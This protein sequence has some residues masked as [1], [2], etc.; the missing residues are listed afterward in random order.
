MLSAENEL[1]VPG[2]GGAELMRYSTGSF[3]SHED[4]GSAHSTGK[5]GAILFANGTTLNELIDPIGERAQLVE[6][7]SEPAS[8]FLPLSECTAADP[9]H[10]A[11]PTDWFPVA[12]AL[13]VALDRWAAQETPPP[14]SKWLRPGCNPAED[15]ACDPRPPRD[16]KGNAL[17]GIRLPDVEVGRGR[18]YSGAGLDL[19]P[20]LVGGYVDLSSSFASHGQYVDAFARQARRLVSE[21]YLLDDDASRLIEGAARSSVGRAGR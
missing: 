18:F 10:C 7:T 1:G 5:D 21:G 20:G 6:V 4:A 8:W 13:L 15:P 17:G 16:A 19:P 3:R 2:N 11:N 9:Y 14:P 12:R